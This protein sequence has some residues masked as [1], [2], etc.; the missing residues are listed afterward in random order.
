MIVMITLLT[1]LLLDDDSDSDSE[2]ESTVKR[3]RSNCDEILVAEFTADR[4][5]GSQKQFW[6]LL[7]DGDPEDWYKDYRMKKSTLKRFAQIACLTCIQ[8][9]W[10]MLVRRE[11]NC[12][13]IVQELVLPLSFDGSLQSLTSTILEKI[14]ASNSQLYH[15]DFCEG[16]EPF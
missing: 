15:V 4:R 5:F 1:T 10:V 3:I 11:G 2:F 12:K 14:S 8:I 9:L 16:A 7:N 13:K 6:D